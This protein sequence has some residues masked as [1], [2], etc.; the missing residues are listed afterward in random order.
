MI[1]VHDSMPQFRD[2]DQSR[3]AVTQDVDEVQ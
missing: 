3:L 2:D 1:G